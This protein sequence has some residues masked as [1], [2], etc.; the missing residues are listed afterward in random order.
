M[1]SVVNGVISGE[2]E[3]ENG[4]WQTLLAGSKN[5][6]NLGGNIETTDLTAPPILITVDQ[7]ICELK[8]VIIA[9]SLI[10]Q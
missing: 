8:E 3:A 10:V 9:C 6:Y 7:L 5:V 4:F 1:D 2:S